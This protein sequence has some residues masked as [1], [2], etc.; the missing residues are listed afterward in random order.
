MPTNTYSTLTRPAA[1]LAGGAASAAQA[2]S[3]PV[4]SFE[5]NNFRNG[6]VT[7][8]EAQEEKDWR[9]RISLPPNADRALYDTLSPEGKSLMQAADGVISS[10]KTI[11]NILP[12][13]RTRKVFWFLKRFREGPSCSD[14]VLR[15]YRQSYFLALRAKS[16]SASSA[17][18]RATFMAHT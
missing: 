15:W 10:N 14:T 4:I 1:S 2:R 16:Q 6:S 9:V 8:K 18:G 11:C 5:S 13:I 12:E 3:M 17:M 7:T